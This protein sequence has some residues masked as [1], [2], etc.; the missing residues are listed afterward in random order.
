MTKL[1]KKVA[2]AAAGPRGKNH[3]LALR[4]SDV[5]PSLLLPSSKSG[6]LR[7]QDA[8]AGIIPKLMPESV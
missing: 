7:E 1:T 8:G 6:P 2:A 5:G 4:R 3:G